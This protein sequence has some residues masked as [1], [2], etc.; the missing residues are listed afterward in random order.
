[1]Q[2]LI[3]RSNITSHVKMAIINQK[4]PILNAKTLLIN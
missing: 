1:M 3:N 2:N 4:L